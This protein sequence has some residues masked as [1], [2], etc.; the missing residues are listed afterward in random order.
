MVL[1]RIRLF[2]FASHLVADRFSL[3]HQPD[4]VSLPPHLRGIVVVDE[5]GHR[6]RCMLIRSKRTLVV[7]EY[8]VSMRPGTHIEACT[9]TGVVPS[10]VRAA[11]VT[12]TSHHTEE[13]RRLDFTG[14]ST[15]GPSDDFSFS[16]DPYGS[17]WLDESSWADTASL[18]EFFGRPSYTPMISNLVPIEFSFVPESYPA[19]SMSPSIA[20]I[21]DLQNL[22]TCL[23]PPLT[24]LSSYLLVS[25]LKVL[26]YLSGRHCV[27][28]RSFYVRQLRSLSILRAG[29]T[30]PELEERVAR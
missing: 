23:L 9:F 16:L 28:R 14:F 27:A 18:T 22:G 3:T 20:L 30:L 11:D 6:W 19:D 7:A 10:P 21:Q 5:R 1:E 26:S 17:F 2:F 25:G 8:F 29:A 4:S 15:L 24:R 13:P 12:S